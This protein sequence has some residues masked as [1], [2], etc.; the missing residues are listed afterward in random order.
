MYAKEII[1]NIMTGDVIFNYDVHDRF[2]NYIY[3]PFFRKET[4]DRKKNLGMDRKK[5]C[6][7]QTQVSWRDLYCINATPRNF[8][9]Y[10]THCYR[11]MMR[12]PSNMMRTCC[13]K[14]RDF[15]FVTFVK[16]PNREEVHTKQSIT[17]PIVMSC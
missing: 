10:L 1:Q 16:E 6:K 14:G 4:R 8:V 12:L 9:K 7:N 5:A 2:I 3:E 13:T 17:D 11:D 15:G